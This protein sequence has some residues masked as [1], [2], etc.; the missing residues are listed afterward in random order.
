MNILTRV[1]AMRRHDFRG[2]VQVRP[3]ADLAD[4][5]FPGRRGLTACWSVDSLDDRP[6]CLWSPEPSAG[7]ADVCDDEDED[8][9]LWRGAVWRRGATPRTRARHESFTRTVCIARAR[10]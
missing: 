1:H 9:R 7:E 2:A 4:M 6:V 8:L 5:R 3:P 10:T